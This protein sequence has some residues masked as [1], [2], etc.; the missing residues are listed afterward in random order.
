MDPK[1][2][3]EERLSRVQ[4]MLTK[5]N[6]DS[7]TFRLVSAKAKVV[8][9]VAATPKPSLPPARTTNKHQRLFQRQPSQR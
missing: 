9:V 4:H 8:T 7:A 5:L 6:K 2:I 3:E 1:D